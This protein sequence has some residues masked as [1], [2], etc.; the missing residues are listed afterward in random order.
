M[1]WASAWAVRDLASMVR[2]DFSDRLTRALGRCTP[3]TGS[4]R[5]NRK[6]IEANPG[7]CARSC[8]TK[9]LMLPF[10]VYM[11]AA[12]GRTVRSGGN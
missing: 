8:A 3:E 4:I 10:G 6:L 2:V 7:S 9:S 1:E 12:H 11:G 5:L